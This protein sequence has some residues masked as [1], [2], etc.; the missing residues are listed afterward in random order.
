MEVAQKL[1]IKYGL[2]RD[3]T[4]A[5]IAEWSRVARNLI[6]DGEAA[7]KAGELAAQYNLPGYRSHVFKTEAD[8]IE[9]LLRE[10]GKK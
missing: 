7:E 4:E 3:P 8:N 1:R 6:A 9:A 2:D 10:L 5:E